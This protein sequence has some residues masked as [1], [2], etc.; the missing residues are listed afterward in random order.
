M[1]P[2]RAVN[3]QMIRRHDPLQCLSVDADLKQIRFPIARLTAGVARRF[4]GNV[5]RFYVQQIVRRIGHDSVSPATTYGCHGYTKPPP[6]SNHLSERSACNL[7]Q[8]SC[9][10]CYTDPKRTAFREVKTFMQ[11]TFALTTAT[12]SNIKS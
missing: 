7:Q 12:D 8:S 3:K 1:R 6:S 11:H 10:R 2:L 5:R 4:V 9:C